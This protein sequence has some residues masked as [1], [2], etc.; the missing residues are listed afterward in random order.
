MLDL[1]IEVAH[2][3]NQRPQYFLKIGPFMAPDITG[4]AWAFA[5]HKH[6]P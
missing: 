2:A 6:Q 4:I 3:I 5:L 1:S